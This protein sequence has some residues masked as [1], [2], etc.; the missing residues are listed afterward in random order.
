MKKQIF[1]NCV[2]HGY[3]FDSERETDIK[4]EPLCYRL[5][6]MGDDDFEKIRL[7]SHGGRAAKLRNTDY[8]TTCKYYGDSPELTSS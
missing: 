8:C 6:V 1:E 5:E 3:N 4:D 7:C 2:S